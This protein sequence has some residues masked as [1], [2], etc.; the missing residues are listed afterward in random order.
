MKEL[1][2]HEKNRN[3]THEH[4]HNTE[5]KKSQKDICTVIQFL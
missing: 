3:K 4:E 5:W 2:L 1:W